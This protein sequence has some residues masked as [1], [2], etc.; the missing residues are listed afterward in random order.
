M[1]SENYRPDTLGFNGGGILSISIRKC[2]LEEMI[3]GLI[4]KR[5]VVAPQQEITR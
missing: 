3:V 2:F 1:S 4:L 5:S